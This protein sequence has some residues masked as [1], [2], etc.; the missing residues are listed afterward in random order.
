MN[1]YQNK[2]HMKNF[3][4]FLISSFYFIT[5]TTSQTSPI[6]YSASGEMIFSFADIEDHGQEANSL[7]RWAPFVNIQAFANKDLSE[8]I[9][10]FSGLAIRNVGYIYD[11]YTIPASQLVVKKK[12]RTY[13]LGIPLGIKVGNLDKLFF[14]GGYEIEFPFVYK[15]KTFDDG[16]KI[17]K[18]SG[19]FSNRPENLQHG[20]LAGVQLPAGINLKF[21]YYFSEF[22][23]QEFTDGSGAKPYEGLESHIFY[24]SLCYMMFKDVKSYY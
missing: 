8:H 7:M 20:L 4:S 9:G 11:D 16:D 14:Y 10:L 22:H 12:F 19:W 18:I 21:K 23:N 3:L 13:N 24:F 6:Y 15:E 1:N 5:S 17:N 2:P